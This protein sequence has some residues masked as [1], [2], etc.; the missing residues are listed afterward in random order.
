MENRI[1]EEPENYDNKFRFEDLSFQDFTK[2]GYQGF[3]CKTI[4]ALD[5]DTIKSSIFYWNLKS[6]FLVGK[7]SF[8]N[9]SDSLQDKETYQIL[10]SLWVH[11]K[12]NGKGYPLN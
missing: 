9:C 7:M 2:Q 11:R 3:L 12:K 6:Y 1:R 4:Y 5:L 10:N 8:Y